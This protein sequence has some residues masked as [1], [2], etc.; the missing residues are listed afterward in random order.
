PPELIAQYPLAQRD[1]CK[2][3]L[4]DRSSGRLSTHR[5]NDLPSLLKPGDALILNDTRVFPARL[6]TTRE[7]GDGEVEILL[8]KELEPDRWE[9]L[10][11][12][13]HRAKPGQRLKI[14]SLATCEVEAQTPGGGRVV[15]FHHNYS[16][17]FE[18]LE[19]FGRSPL[20]PYIRR[21]PEPADRETYQTVFARERGAVA[22]PTAGL[23]FTA[24]LLAAVKVAG[25]RI[26]YLTL[27]VG[28]GTFQ[29]VRVEDI[30]H[31][32]MAA[33][34]YRLGPETASLINETARLGGRVLAVGTTVT[35]T[36]ETTATGGGQVAPGGGW[37]EAFIYPPYD[38]KAISGLV[39]NFHLPKST[40][41]MLVSA[42]AGRELV[43]GSYQ[44]AVKERYRFYSY[45]DA[46]LIL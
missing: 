39:T 9:A 29:P 19:D 35:R 44:Q 6:I 17:L 22:A 8:L 2:L 27:H 40:L 31:H 26:G 15:R 46:M 16:S 10:A 37:T 32:R 3:M 12:P 23:H 33:E 7:G 24:E 34:Y 45:G 36:L 1:Q 13:G 4:V 42:F 14:D 5:F 20:P 43:L 28:L 30:S 38:F 21:D 11:K 18:L 25:I 41:L